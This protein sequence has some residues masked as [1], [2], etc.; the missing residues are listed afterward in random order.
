MT[1]PMVIFLNLINKATQQNSTSEHDNMEVVLL[2]ILY[3]APSLNI[4][5]NMIN[6]YFFVNNNA[7]LEC[8]NVTSALQ[9][10]VRVFG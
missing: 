4:T 6:L 5:S 10:I 7:L 3:G 2:T 8:D 9:R 1:Y